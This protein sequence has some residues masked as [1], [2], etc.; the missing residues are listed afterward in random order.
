MLYDN[1]SE[2]PWVPMMV[3]GPGRNES[4]AHATGRRLYARHCIYCHGV[5]RKGDA[6]SEGPVVGDTHDQTFFSCH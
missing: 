6:P 3:S 4:R 1:A 2:I 5:D